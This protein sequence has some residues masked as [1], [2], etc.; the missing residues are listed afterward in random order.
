MYEKIREETP[1]APVRRKPNFL[2]SKNLLWGI[3]KD[4]DKRENPS[5][6]KQVSERDFL[7]TSSMDFETVLSPKSLPLILCIYV[8]Q[9]R[10]VKLIRGDLLSFFRRMECVNCLFVFDPKT[11]ME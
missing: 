3:M 11:S 1:N 2:E 10:N 7:R 4:E 6:N 8:V 9:F 5:T